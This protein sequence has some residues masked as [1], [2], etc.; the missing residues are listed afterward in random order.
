MESSIP[1]P[2]LKHICIYN[3]VNITDTGINA[4]LKCCP[5]L[6]SIDING[7]YLTNASMVGIFGRCKKLKRLSFGCN[8]HISGDMFDRK[9]NLEILHI[10]SAMDEVIIKM[11]HVCPDL[12]D[13]NLNYSHNITGNIVE[14]LTKNCPKIEVLKLSSGTLSRSEIIRLLMAYPRLKKLDVRSI[15]DIVADIAKYCTNLEILTILW[16]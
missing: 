4:L 13:L 6:E 8:P 7:I 16:W 15:T 10:V 5:R 12:V 9:T 11:S 2:K 1:A 14:H 3:S